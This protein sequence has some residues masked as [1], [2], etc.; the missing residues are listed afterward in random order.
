MQS[1]RDFEGCEHNKLL[2]K[3]VAEHVISLVQHINVTV[4]F[5]FSIWKMHQKFRRA[6]PT[7]RRPLLISLLYFS[8]F[9]SGRFKPTDGYNCIDNYLISYVNCDDDGDFGQA[10]VDKT[11]ISYVQG[12]II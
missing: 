8:S 5:F 4:V 3:H 7:K 11:Y 9:S 12:K 10:T 1:Q 6:F 2:L